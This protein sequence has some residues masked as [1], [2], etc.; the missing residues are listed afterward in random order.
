MLQSII[1]NQ[2]AKIRPTDYAIT[3]RHVT[4]LIRNLSDSKPHDCLDQMDRFI[5]DVVSDVFFGES[6]D[7][8]STELQPLRV[9]VEEMYLWNTQRILIGYVTTPA[10]GENKC[11]I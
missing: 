2:T 4:A 10:H 5:L 9:A 8:L 3:E 6:A 7:T 1:T 11:T